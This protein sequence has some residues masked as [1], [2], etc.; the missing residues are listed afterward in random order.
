MGSIPTIFVFIF[1]FVSTLFLFGLPFIVPVYLMQIL[2]SPVSLLPE[3][4]VAYL[5]LTAII[6]GFYSFI[7]WIDEE[8]AELFVL[9]KIGPE[10]F[11]ECHQEARENR[12]S[13]I[14]KSVWHRLT[15]PRPRLV[16]WVYRRLSNS[17][18]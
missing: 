7:A 11:R 2:Q 13:G 4:V 8:Y 5:I 16:L 12:N 18:S 6:V 9:S 15:Y 17:N 1:R 10:K 3:I 14:I